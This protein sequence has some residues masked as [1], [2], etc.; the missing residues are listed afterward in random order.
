M[1]H[2]PRDTQFSIEYDFTKLET[3]YS[4]LAIEDMPHNLTNPPEM[5]SEWSTTTS[6]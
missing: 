3:S 2:P 5:M 4:W 1:S 6:R